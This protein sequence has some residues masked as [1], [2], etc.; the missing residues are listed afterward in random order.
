MGKKRD[1]EE[2]RGGSKK[3]PHTAHRSYVFAA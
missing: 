2:W 3:F 1:I